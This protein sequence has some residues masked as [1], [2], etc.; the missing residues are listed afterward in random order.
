MAVRLAEIA[1]WIGG[2]LLGD[3]ALEI[4]GLRPLGEAGPRDL[5]FAV[6][7]DAV[8]AARDSRAGALLVAARIEGFTGAQLVVRDP[9]GAFGAVLERL[10]PPRRAKA[11]VH[12]TAI[13]EPTARID[14]A[15]EV[16][17]FVVVGAGSRIGPAA[18]LDAHVVVGRDC[19]VGAACHLHAHAVLYDGTRIGAGSIVHAGAVVGSD[20]FGYRTAGGLPRKIP[21]VGRVEVGDEVEIGA[22]STIDRAT[23]GVTAVGAHAKIDNL[24]QVGHNVTIGRGAILCAQTGIAGSTRLGDGVVL[25]GQVGVA[26]H[27]VVGAGVQVAAKSAVM[28]DVEPGQVVAGIPAVPAPLWRRQQ[29]LLRRLADWRSRLRRLEQRLEGRGEEE[30]VD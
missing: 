1:G 2:E 12:P 21:Q 24:V 13:V 4:E 28:Q 3:G 19:E 14:P 9:R 8:T 11:G 17:P 26:D 15:A 10:H 23:L 20:G 16:G 7:P 27:R 18:I 29:A 5:A 6:G 30:S 22:N 25:A